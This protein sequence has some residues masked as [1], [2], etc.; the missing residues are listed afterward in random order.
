M[1]TQQFLKGLLMAIIGVAVTVLSTTPIDVAVLIITLIGN[2][3]LYVGKNSI[4]FLRSDS[5]PN[6]VSWVNIISAIIILI[7]NGLVDSIAQWAI[8]G[9]IQW[10]PML[11]FAA[12]VTFTYFGTTVFAGLYSTLKTKFFKPLNK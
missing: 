3:L 10:G 2:I 6:M 7:G 5:A 1:T 4:V 9:V 11:K 12:S 8:N